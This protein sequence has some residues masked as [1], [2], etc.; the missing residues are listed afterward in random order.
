MD[1]PND[2]HH[3]VSGAE[4]RN[5]PR[6]P[7]TIPFFVRGSKSN[8]DEVLEFANALD[9]SAGGVLL[10]TKR[11]LERGTQISLEVPTAL[12]HKAHLPQSVSLLHATVLRCTPEREYFLV[13]LQFMKPLIA[14]SVESE[15]D[16]SAAN[17]GEHL[18]PE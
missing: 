16:S 12:V 9:I 18:N 1:T 14:A 11:Y 13:G 7:L 6:L 10:V 5:W 15:N 4:R 8:G 17:M 3:P 2:G